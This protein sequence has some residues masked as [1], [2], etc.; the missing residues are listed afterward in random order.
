[1]QDRHHITDLTGNSI[2]PGLV[3]FQPG[4]RV[5][6]QTQTY[7]GHCLPAEA[8]AVDPRSRLRHAKQIQRHTCLRYK[9]FA[10]SGHTDVTLAPN[11]QALL[12][13]RAV[14]PSRKSPQSRSNNHPC[15]STVRRFCK[16]VS[17]NTI[18]LP[19]VD[20]VVACPVITAAIFQDTWGSDRALEQ[21]G[22]G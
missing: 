13:R 16:W 3:Q 12:V 2:R 8:D 17:A 20:S 11:V 10:R 1:M 6:R 15:D 5:G 7:A 9:Q 22:P 4:C 14:R 19:A 18:G 21:H